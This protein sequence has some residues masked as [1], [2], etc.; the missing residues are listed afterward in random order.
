MNQS[1]LI[2]KQIQDC[3]ALF[4]FTP[5]ETIV[6]HLKRALQYRLEGKSPEAVR[7][8]YLKDLE[9]PQI[10]LFDILA[11]R[12]PLVLKAQQIVSKAILQQVQGKKHITLLDLGIGRG[13]QAKRIIEVL[14]NVV[15]LQSLTLIGVEIFK[16]ALDFTDQLLNNL[17]SSLNIELNFIP[18]HSSV[19]NV[20]LEN[21]KQHIPSNNECTLVNASLTLH[22]VQTNEIRSEIFYKIASL[23]PA[24]VTLIEPNTDCHTNNFEDR[25][26]NVY[27]HFSALY[28][29]I[30]TLDLLPEE[31]KGLKQFFS[32]ELFDAVALPDEHRFEQYAPSTE[33]IDI[34]IKQGLSPI[35]ISPSAKNVQIEHIDIE[36][37]IS[38]IINFKYQDSNILGVITLQT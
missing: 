15:G 2:E 16:E 22:H 24:L 10:I 8:T 12:F 37:P 36:N 33:W 29:F 32:T 1:T 13:V 5:D 17:K 34:A 19:E 30:N 26:K 7:N 27:E 11:N 20:H 3:I 14:N 28:L 4:D 35:D 9:I 38:G 18:I 31:K 6:N 23:N 21:I 25:L